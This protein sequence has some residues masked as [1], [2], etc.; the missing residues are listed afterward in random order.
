M[1]HE[2]THGWWLWL[3][4]T[5][6][7]GNTS[8]LEERIISLKLG[9]MKRNLCILN[10][11]TIV[12]SEIEYILVLRQA[13]VKGH[14]AGTRYGASF[15]VELQNSPNLVRLNRMQ[16]IPLTIHCVA[17]T[18]HYLYIRCCMIQ[19]SADFYHKDH[20]ITGK[21][22]RNGNRRLNLRSDIQMKLLANTIPTG[23]TPQPPRAP[24]INQRFSN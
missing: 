9:K 16:L 21:P 13:T 15:V 8:L 11:N 5:I 4:L 6:E 23:G 22:N 17:Y 10:K 1:L 18:R 3:H 7:R 20:R 24:E 14:D 12:S 2:A 19:F